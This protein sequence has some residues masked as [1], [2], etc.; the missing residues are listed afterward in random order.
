MK[1]SVLSVAA[2]ALVF[3][4]VACATNRTYYLAAVE[5][6]WDYAPS[7][8]DQWH[9]V[10]LEE[11][12]DA[13]VFCTRDDTHIGRVYRK[14]IFRGY[15]DETFSQQIETPAWMGF[16]GPVIRAE[17][18]DEVHVVFKNLASR[19]YSIHPHGVHYTKEH[20]GA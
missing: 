12:D 8:I 7:G 2:L 1:P 14:A 20:E 18:G 5:V 17:V 13:A 11:S 3:A 15:T 10:P 6:D 9:N 19:P 4:G 16:L